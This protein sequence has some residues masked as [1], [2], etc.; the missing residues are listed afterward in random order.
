MTITDRLDLCRQL[1]LLKAYKPKKHKARRRF[2]TQ[3]RTIVR[4]LK[5]AA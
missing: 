2:R 5:R 1:V 4:Q 3:R